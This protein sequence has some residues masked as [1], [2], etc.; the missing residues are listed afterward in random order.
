MTDTSKF[1]EAVEQTLLDLEFCL[2]HHP[3]AGMENAKAAILAAHREAVL[4]EL[5]WAISQSPSLH[6]ESDQVDKWEVSHY[7][8]LLRERATQ[9]SPRKVREM[10]KALNREETK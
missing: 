9:L 7:R 5:E 8:E 6:D 1:E 3:M 4:E 10:S 2:R